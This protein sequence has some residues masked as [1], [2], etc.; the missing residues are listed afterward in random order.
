ME[1]KRYDAL[2]QA[3]TELTSG[4]EADGLIE[5]NPEL[6]AE[7]EAAQLARS[8]SEAT[9]PQDAAHRS[10]T[11][12]LARA[13]ELRPEVQPPRGI[14]QR[15]PRLVYALVLALILFVSW[16]GFVIAS[17]QSLPGDQ[18][19]PAKLTL[20]RI[21]LGLALDPQ[22]HQAVE[23][24]YQA[25][26]VDE[27]KSLLSKGR[28]EFVQFFGIVE[29]QWDEHWI[30]EDI[31]VR[32]MPETIILGEISPGMTVEVEGATQPGEWVQ[33]SE[34]HLQK[35]QFTGIVEAISE[36]A[37]IISGKEVLIV[38]ISTVE[39]DV[40]I[41]D[42]VVVDV[43]SDDFGNLTATTITV[44]IE[45]GPELSETETP[46]PS[47]ESSET[48][49]LDETEEAEERDETDEADDLEETDTPDETDEPDEPDETDASDER[50][51]T[52]E[53]E[54]TEKS[55]KSDQSDKPDETDEADEP[56]GS[57][58]SNEADESDDD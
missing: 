9:I 56:D 21:R 47:L 44:K 12:M 31:E 1:E 20:E 25:R 34:I 13:M 3:L 15:L 16:N 42:L 6:A 53:A 57:D 54:K 27:V 5:A 19:Y 36:A 43:T 8:L 4:Q 33:A 39:P 29:Q 49:D 2:E 58:E 37:W 7:I 32:L 40:E 22:I 45:N 52:D 11:R 14:F 23:E 24:D 30:I 48:D 18:L 50:D 17:A 46:S 55:N 28:I 26:R 35:F 38:P 10:R 41:G 51:E